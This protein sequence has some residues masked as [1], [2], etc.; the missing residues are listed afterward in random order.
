M[1]I[2]LKLKQFENCAKFWFLIDFG[3]FDF[4]RVFSAIKQSFKILF[5]Q[6][7]KAI[8]IGC[9]VRCLHFEKCV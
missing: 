4:N 8:S 7:F 9:R 3:N 6:R 1:S 5:V 2:L